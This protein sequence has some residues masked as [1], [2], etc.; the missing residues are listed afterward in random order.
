VII[1]GRSLFKGNRA[2]GQNAD[3]FGGNGGVATMHNHSRTLVSGHTIFDGNNATNNGECFGLPLLQHSLL[4]TMIHTFP[5]LLQ[6]GRL[7]CLT[8]RTCP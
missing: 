4:F 2:S 8:L 6:V 5:Y 1:K 3:D 7:R